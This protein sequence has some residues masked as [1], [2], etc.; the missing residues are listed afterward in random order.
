M[1]HVQGL[2]CRE[3][4]REY[5]AAPIYTCEWCFGPLEVA[6]DYDAIAKAASREKIAAGPVRIIDGPQQLADFQPG[7]VLVAQ[8]TSPDWEPVMKIAAAIVTERGG[9]TCHA[10]IVAREL[11]VPAVVGAAGAKEA[12]RTGA[13]VTVSCA[14]GDDGFVYAGTADFVAEDVDLSHVPETRTKVML[15]LAD[16]AAAFRWWRLPADGVGL[17][18][19]EFVVSNAIKVHPMALVRFEALK[20]ADART[21]IAELTRGYPDKAEYFVGRLALGL[22]RIAAAYH[23]KPVIVRMSDF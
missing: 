7:E 11:G 14:E 19:M 20:D 6:Y 22:A 12:L 21:R 18:R 2:K 15:N 3:C 17:A 4:G 5:E 23:P 9:R 16:P 13:V 8:S 1:V 10:A